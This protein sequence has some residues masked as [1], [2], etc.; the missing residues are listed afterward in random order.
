[1]FTAAGIG[2]VQVLHN[3]HMRLAFMKPVTTSPELAVKL[4][5][6]LRAAHSSVKATGESALRDTAGAVTSRVNG[7]LDRLADVPATGWLET[8]RTLASDRAALDVRQHAWNA[9]DAAI[10]TNSL[11]FATWWVRDDVETLVFLKTGD[12][13]EWTREE[14]RHFGWAHA[15]AEAAALALLARVHLRDQDFRTLIAPFRRCISE[16]DE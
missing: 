14:R 1:M 2:W 3:R 6:Q 5:R 16:S 13:R 7:F 12:M 10:A 11:C 9:L 8:G 4:V 15:A